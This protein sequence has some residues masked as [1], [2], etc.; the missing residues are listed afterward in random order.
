M[1]YDWQERGKSFLCWLERIE[2][3]REKGEGECFG[4]EM[5]EGK[6]EDIRRKSKFPSI[7]SLTSQKNPFLLSHKTWQGLLP[8]GEDFRSQVFPS[9]GDAVC[10]L[11]TGNSNQRNQDNA[12]KVNYLLKWQGCFINQK[13][14]S[15]N[16][17][18]LSVHLF[19]SRGNFIGKT[20]T[21][22]TSGSPCGDCPSDCD[23]GLCSK[24]FFKS[25]IKPTL[26]KVM[27][28]KNRF[29]MRS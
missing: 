27:S 17:W 28:A 23:N 9:D 19:H 29:H 1:A 16:V 11:K 5:K 15:N 20:A 2:K 7:L 4:G 8:F 6:K 24:F 26:L 18:H 14:N 21:P 13:W 25:I 10:S 12:T 3:D 22:Y